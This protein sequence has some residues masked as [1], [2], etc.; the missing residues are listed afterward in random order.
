MKFEDKKQYLCAIGTIL[1]NEI[2]DY[3]VGTY[4]KFN[5][6]FSFKNGCGA[7]TEL[8]FNKKDGS[9]ITCVLKVKLIDEI[10]L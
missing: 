1:N 4:Y 10:E 2:K 9:N 6:L 7:N 8:F 5:D 3:S